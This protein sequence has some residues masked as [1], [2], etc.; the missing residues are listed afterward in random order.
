MGLNRI[1]NLNVNNSK[2]FGEIFNVILTQTINPE[3]IHSKNTKSTNSIRKRC[4]E[5]EKM[6]INSSFNIY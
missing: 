4:K 6:K 1:N 2:I 3:E 5:R